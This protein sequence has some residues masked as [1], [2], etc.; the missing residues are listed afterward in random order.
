[1]S[2]FLNSSAVVAA[3]AVAG[4]VGNSTDLNHP[5]MNTHHLIPNDAVAMAA[6][7]MQHY[8]N[9]LANSSLSSTSSSSSS[10]SSSSGSCNSS[11]T[12]NLHH[13]HSTSNSLINNDSLK[14]YATHF[15]SNY[16]SGHKRKRRILFTQAQVNELEKRFTKSRY[17]SA[18]ERELLANGLNLTPTQVK[19][20]FQNHRYKTKKSMK[21]RLKDDSNYF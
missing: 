10:S 18:P 11:S 5:Q 3:A 21:E 13:A 9:S 20:W 1:V 16:S 12:A 14:Q 19:I 8:H 17:L 6:A 7:S 15:T 2:K 4:A